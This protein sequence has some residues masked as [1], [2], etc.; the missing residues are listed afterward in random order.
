MKEVPMEMRK[1]FHLNLNENKT[2]QHLQAVTEACKHGLKINDQGRY[3][4]KFGERNKLK[5]KKIYKENKELR[6]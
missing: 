1:C 5:I 2:Y 4:G 6:S 3:F